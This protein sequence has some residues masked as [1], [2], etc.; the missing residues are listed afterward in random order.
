MT[1]Y[2]SHF[3]TPNCVGGRQVILSPLANSL[4][5]WVAINITA[6][7]LAQHHLEKNC[8]FLCS[9]SV[10][11]C[12]CV[13]VYLLHGVPAVLCKQKMPSAMLSFALFWRL[14]AHLAKVAAKLGRKQEA[15]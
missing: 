6:E 11:S 7:H 15:L 12:V 2:K 8:L 10:V 1:I 14:I 3:E 5:C 9:F 13:Y 4:A